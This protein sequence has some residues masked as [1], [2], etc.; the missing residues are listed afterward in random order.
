MGCGDRISISRFLDNSH[1]GCS[2]R[3]EDDSSRISATSAS[4]LQIWTL[5]DD[6]GG[7]RASY[8]G[9]M[10]QHLRRY[11]SS[12]KHWSAKATRALRNKTEGTR[13]A[14]KQNEVDIQRVIQRWR[15]GRCNVL[16]TTSWRTC[17]MSKKE[18]S[19]RVVEISRNTPTSKSDHV[20]TIWR[21]LSP[22]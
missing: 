5:V 17:Y 1:I 21:L 4:L 16:W 3:F 12:W 6:F 20:W 18:F 10:K 13:S 22:R 9:E 7:T 8:I 2:S 14:N 15:E 11:L 19:D